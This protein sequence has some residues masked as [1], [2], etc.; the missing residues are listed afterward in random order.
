M[1]VTPNIEAILC[2]RKYLGRLNP[3]V[4]SRCR[5]S[6]AATISFIFRLHFCTG[7]NMEATVFHTGELSVGLEAEGL[8]KMQL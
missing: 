1:L 4:Q 2:T 5:N 8:L 6:G 7:Q 3:D